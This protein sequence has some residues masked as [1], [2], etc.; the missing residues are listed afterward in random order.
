M[1]VQLAAEICDAG[2]WTLERSCLWDQR[3]REVRSVFFFVLGLTGWVS[4]RIHI[5]LRFIQN[6]VLL[7]LFCETAFYSERS[8]PLSL[9]RDFLY[10]LF[11]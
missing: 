8:P 2:I 4:N 5:V 7:F 9:L 1:D 6:V 10:I 3:N 11:C